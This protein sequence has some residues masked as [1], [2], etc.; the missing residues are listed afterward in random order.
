MAK[1]EALGALPGQRAADRRGA[2][3]TPRPL[4]GSLPRS[5]GRGHDGDRR[6]SHSSASSLRGGQ[7][8]THHGRAVAPSSAVAGRG[9][10]GAFPPAV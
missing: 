5:C 6:L 3:G 4:C 2:R 9:C 10:G 7:C 8:Q 1:G